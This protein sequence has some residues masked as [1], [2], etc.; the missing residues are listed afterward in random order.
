MAV[1]RSLATEMRRQL[2]GG[3]TLRRMPLKHRLSRHHGVVV[4]STGVQM[5]ADIVP[6]WRFGAIP[7]G[8]VITILRMIG[9]AI[10]TRPGS[11]CILIKG[12][13]S[14]IRRWLH[15]VLRRAKRSVAG[16]RRFMRRRAV[17]RWWAL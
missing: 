2:I 13:L 14:L 1:R 5:L 11:I 4:S 12:E 7:S 15:A 16:T 8:P 9:T 3:I 10:P 17:L 6:R